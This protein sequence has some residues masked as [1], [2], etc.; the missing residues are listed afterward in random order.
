MTP[1]FLAQFA[2]GCF[3]AVAVSSIRQCGW[4]Y[5]RLMAVV[6]LAVGFFSALLVV[7]EPAASGDAYRT[8]ALAG[9]GGAVLLATVWL[10]VNAAQ[11]ERI[12]GVQRVLPAAASV[13]A[14]VAA[15]ALSQ[16]PD[17]LLAGGSRV[18]GAA[19]PH[20]LALGVSTALGAALL[21]LATAA[22][23][24]GHRYLTDTDMPIAPLRRLARLYLAAVALRIV[25]V[26]AASAPIWS[27]GF[28]PAS[29]YVWF[30]VMMT[31]RVGVGLLGTAVFAYMVWDCVRRR[32]TQSA[33]AL[34]YLSMVFVFLGELAGQYLARTEALAM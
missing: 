9:L 18:A 23:L 26:G 15:V 2:A 12:G 4:K 21:G 29:D 10:F 17:A 6:S 33:T 5:L 24:L 27:A 31:V 30:W 25:W 13:L 32:A 19:T 3:L 20:L 1:A 28:R 34:F 16:R 14:M 8:A 22:M 11:G 7:R